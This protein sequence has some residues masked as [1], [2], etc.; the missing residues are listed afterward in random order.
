MQSVRNVR[1]LASMRKQLLLLLIAASP[2]WSGF[3]VSRLGSAFVIPSRSME[4]TL[5]VGERERKACEREA[6]ER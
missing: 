5:E 3:F 6:C 4:I 2:L 1:G